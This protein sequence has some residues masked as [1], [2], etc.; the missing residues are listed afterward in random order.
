VSSLGV[1][2]RAAAPGTARAYQALNAY[3]DRI[4]VV[5]LRRATDRHVQLA[6]A[7]AGL[8]YEI[9]HGQD[10]L[11][12]DREDLL[13]RGVYDDRAARRL[14]RQGRGMHLG[15][16]AC[17]LSHVA[18]WRRI[19]GEGQRRVLVFEDDAVPVEGAID[20]APEALA[21]LPE[22]WELLYLG[23]DR[24]EA[25]TLRRRLNQAAYV[26]LGA[27]GLIRWSASEA[28]NLLP[29]PYSANLRRAGFHDYTHA[30]AVTAS[31]AAKLLAFQTPVVM[32]ADSAM[33]RLVLRGQLEAYVTEPK[34]FVQKPGSSYVA[35]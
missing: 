17:A 34:L 31:A 10:K 28:G 30:Y 25:V 23:Y 3:F 14:H 35:E 7:L 15:Q 33:T 18:V 21:Q 11:E 13:R 6:R 1:E 4:W 27:L 20:R 8:R 32:N 24:N 2:T 9:F 22:S 19:V 26:A 29:R 5:T 12:L 16:V